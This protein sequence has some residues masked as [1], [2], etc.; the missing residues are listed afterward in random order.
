MTKISKRKLAALY[1][2]TAKAFE[3]NEYEWTTGRFG[4]SGFGEHCAIGGLYH[5]AVK[6]GLVPAY[7][8]WN[9]SEQVRDL[10]CERAA[11]QKL[12][13]KYI[14]T[15]TFNDEYAASKEDVIKHLR[16]TAR[17]LEHG[18]KV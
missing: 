3:A 11:S 8:P 16:M 18:G 4:A 1:R 6:S 14:S 7:D 17:A 12:I 13:G 9:K 15:I 5:E 10:A 2:Q